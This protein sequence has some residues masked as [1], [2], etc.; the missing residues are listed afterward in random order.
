M[1]TIREFDDDVQGFYKF[2]KYE[3]NRLINI[4]KLRKLLKT[5]IETKKINLFEI[6]CF[7]N[8][9]VVLI[10]VNNKI[11]E[12]NIHKDNEEQ[13][14]IPNIVDVHEEFITDIV[15][16]HEEIIP[17][18]VDGKELQFYEPYK[19]DNEF[20]ENNKE[21]Y[22]ELLNFFNLKKEELFNDFS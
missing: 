14:I 9:Y 13:E 4:N 12:I 6:N 19:L 10:F 15:E 21:I 11:I 1:N 17:D 7:D 3:F 18:I 22:D 2:D 20:Y 5:C 8:C 16:V